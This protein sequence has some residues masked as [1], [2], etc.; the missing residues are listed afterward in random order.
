MFNITEVEHEAET[1]VGETEEE[2]GH[3]EFL[4]HA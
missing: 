3:A 2:L 4:F 1:M